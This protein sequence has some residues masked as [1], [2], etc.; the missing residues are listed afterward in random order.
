M[1][2]SNLLLQPSIVAA[3]LDKARLRAGFRQIYRKYRASTL[4]HERKYIA[5]LEIVWG[6]RKIPG[7]VVECGVWR[8]GMI[9]GIADVLGPDRQYFLLDSFEGLPR[10]RPEVDG[11][12]V[13]AWQSDVTSPAYYNNCKA[14]EAEAAASMNLSRATTFSLVKGWFNETVP[15]FNP[16][17]EIAVLRLDG[18]LYDST[19]ICLEYLFPK[20]ADGGVVL[21]DD[22]YDWDGCARAVN[23]YVSRSDVPS[24]VPRIRQF[25]DHALAYIVKRA[26]PSSTPYRIT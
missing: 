15:K 13:I 17:S 8:G 21:I 19:R 22:Y 16:P 20:V 10:A 26:A 3:R 4:I 18:D 12:A 25:R 14:E 5:N 1:S 23:E 9:A 6:V 2:I 11:A 7:C 24:A